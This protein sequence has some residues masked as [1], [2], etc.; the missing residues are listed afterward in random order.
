LDERAF[1]RLA[2][3]HLPESAGEPDAVLGV[4][5]D[6]ATGAIRQRHRRLVLAHHP[7]KLIAQGMPKDFV[8]LA[9]QRLAAFN[10]AWDRIRAERGKT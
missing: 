8:V 3:R 9:N 10:A 5:P 1:A 7:D 4:S 6:A 2:A